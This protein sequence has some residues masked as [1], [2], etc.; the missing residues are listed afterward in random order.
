MNDAGEQ[1]KRRQSRPGS[2]ERSLPPVGPN[3]RADAQS[4]LHETAGNN[5]AEP[6]AGARTRQPKNNFRIHA[7][8]ARKNCL[9]AELR[10]PG[11]FDIYCASR[12]KSVSELAPGLFDCATR[13]A[14][15]EFCTMK[16]LSHSDWAA[17]STALPLLY[18]QRNTVNIAFTW[19]KI[20]KQLTAA[21]L[22]VSDELD[23][24]TFKVNR[25]VAYPYDPE[26]VKL[27]PAF[28]ALTGK[29][30]EFRA[31][32]SEGVLFGPATS[33]LSQRQFE[34]TDVFN[35]FH[36]PLGLRY[37]FAGFASGLT[38]PHIGFVVHRKSRDYSQRDESVLRHLAEHY[39]AAAMNV[40]A[41]ATVAGENHSLTQAHEL[42]GHG[43][44]FLNAD[45][46]LRRM[47]PMAGKQ[48]A[49]FFADWRNRSSL[50]ESVTRWMRHQ[51]A[52]LTE[53][54]AIGSPCQSMKAACG[55][56]LLTIRLVL[57]QNEPPVLILNE[58]SDVISIDVL[59]RF[60]LTPRE[61]EVLYW[62]VQGKTNSEIAI[63][64]GT[65]EGTARK[66]VERILTHFG[67][68]NRT[69]TVLHVMEQLR[70]FAE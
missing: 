38:P 34:R 23:T 19:M 16:R 49:N 14:L 8:F 4:T 51:I 69:V 53:H 66:H 22:V 44:V 48:F 18:S 68:H 67:T 21:D 64:L 57:D 17:I 32:Y 29:V 3:S 37:Q 39:A 52:N 47:T 13:F 25:P 30:P 31:G 40:R 35:A 58:S 65:R 33:R 54:R 20:V 15:R 6:T 10:T 24:S 50:P 42:A 63:L 7:E 27:A 61:T 12:N 1:K 60:G 70:S 2:A 59:S 45:Y 41:F 11:R 55:E 28:L 43:I 46:T 62:L 56:K 26:V 36:R 9:Y 5:N